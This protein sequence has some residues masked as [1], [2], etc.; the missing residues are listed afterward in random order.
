MRTAVLVCLTVGVLAALMVFY[1]YKHKNSLPTESHTESHGEQSTN[2]EPMMDSLLTP[3]MEQEALGGI[4]WGSHARR[5]TQ[6]NRDSESDDNESLSWRDFRRNTK[7]Q[8]E[9]AS[10][11]D[12]EYSDKCLCTPGTCVCKY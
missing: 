4:Q 3:E 10:T 7:S 8:Y 11:S 5:L 6:H 1:K 9:P 12:I 2:P